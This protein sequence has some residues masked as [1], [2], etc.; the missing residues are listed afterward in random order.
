M[1]SLLRIRSSVGSAQSSRRDV[2]LI[3]QVKRLFAIEKPKSNSSVAKLPTVRFK[4]GTKF[5]RDSSPHELL[6]L[7][8]VIV[9][10]PVVLAPS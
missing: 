7:P 4:C 10:S 5:E 2:V 8:T 3:V 6:K 9:E 1:V